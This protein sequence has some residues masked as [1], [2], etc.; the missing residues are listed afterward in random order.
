MTGCVED[1]KGYSNLWGHGEDDQQPNCLLLPRG[2]CFELFLSAKASV[3][4]LECIEGESKY[5][6]FTVCNL[7]RTNNKQE[8][9][10]TTFV[11][12][13]QQNE[14]IISTLRTMPIP[15]CHCVRKLLSSLGLNESFVASTSSP[16]SSQECVANHLSRVSSIMGFN[17]SFGSL[18]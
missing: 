9:A 4:S 7:H 14:S 5:S 12:E 8:E 11:V 2:C 18:T 3:S 15:E 13:P 17:L 6:E 10:N 1:R 16:G